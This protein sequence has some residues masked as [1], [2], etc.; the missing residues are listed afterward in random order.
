MVQDVKHNLTPDK[1]NSTRVETNQSLR[2]R[3]KGAFTAWHEAE[4]KDFSSEGVRLMANGNGLSKDKELE[5]ELTLD[6]GASPLRFKGR[7]VWQECG[8]RFTQTKDLSSKERLIYFLT[9]KL[10]PLLL[11][12]R[13][14]RSFHIKKASTTEEKNEASHLVYREYLKRG[15]CGENLE[16]MHSSPFLYQPRSRTFILKEKEKLVGTVGLIPDFVSGLPMES[17][18]SDE[19]RELRMKGRT[20]AEVGFLALDTE[21][22]GRSRFSLSNLRKLTAS[23]KLFKALFDHARFVTQVTDLL[24]AV[25]PKHE[26][27]YRYLKFE[28]MGEVKPYPGACNKPALPMRMDILK[29]VKETPKDKG[30]GLYFLNGEVKRND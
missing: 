2:Y 22:F 14:S 16:K 25:H 4:V 5:L 29:V 10:I 15:Y 19:I 12:E 27:L 23:F 24:I 18:F 7:V 9:Q 26:T 17:I 13:L 6:E 28:R 11:S 3:L 30:P 20:L 1:R 21:H 8:I